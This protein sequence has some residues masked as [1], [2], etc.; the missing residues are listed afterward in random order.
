[1]NHGGDQVTDMTCELTP[2]AGI[3]LAGDG[4]CWLPDGIAGN[5]EETLYFR[6]NIEARLAPGMHMGSAVITYTR[7]DSGLT[8]T[9]PAHPIAWPVDF[10]FA[11]DDPGNGEIYAENQIRATEVVITDNGEGNETNA[12]RQVNIFPLPSDEYEQSTF[13]D[14]LITLDVTVENNGNSDLYNVEFEFAPTGWDF[15]RDPTFFWPTTAGPEYDGTWFMLEEFPVGATETFTIQVIVVKEVP[16][17]EHRLPIIYN[18]FYFNDGSL[19][20]ATEF[21]ATNGGNDLEVYFSVFVTDGHLDCYI[22]NVWVPDGAD[23]NDDTTY[24]FR[25]P[26]DF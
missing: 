11:D 17:G 15:F 9:E 22:D 2:P 26:T 4:T 14:K 24:F 6:S 16:I 5:T 8:I 12:T 19:G 1:M 21:A 7:E 13:S 18:V 10:N 23:Y 20:D 25:D 3:T